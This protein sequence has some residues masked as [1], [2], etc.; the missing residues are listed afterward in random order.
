M[1]KPGLSDSRLNRLRTPL[2]IA[3]L[4]ALAMGFFLSNPHVQVR[5]SLIALVSPLN[6]P[7][8]D[9]IALAIGLLLQIAAGLLAG[10]EQARLLN[11]ASRAKR[12]WVSTTALNWVISWIVWMVVTAGLIWLVYALSLS[13]GAEMAELLQPSALVSAI[14]RLGVVFAIAFS[15]CVLSARGLKHALPEGFH[16][17]K[18]WLLRMGGAW[19][20]AVITL[21]AFFVVAEVVYSFI[22]RPRVE[23]LAAGDIDAFT[24]MMDKAMT[25]S[26]IL[27]MLGLLAGAIVMALMQTGALHPLLRL[28][29]AEAHGEGETPT[30]RGETAP[31]AN[32]DSGPRN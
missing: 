30:L 16:L 5:E 6:A 24:L 4:W 14:L 25:T 12:K 21:G 19:S 9:L 29:E 15:I 18:R 32:F 17:P 23:T 7:A 20:A 3:C 31:G 2:V 28:S 27:H 26:W 22:T 1:Q 8:K 13:G 10:L 11:L